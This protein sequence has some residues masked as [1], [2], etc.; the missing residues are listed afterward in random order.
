VSQA[1]VHLTRALEFAARKHRDQRR[2]GATAEP[3]INHLAEVAR[4]VAE[5]TAGQ[6]PV[7]VTA[8]L[9]HDT[10]EDTKTTAEELSREFGPQV[11]AIV[12]EVTDDKRLPKAER[13]RLQVENAPHKSPRAKL[14][15]IAD[16]I[17]N[18]RAIL[19]SPPVDWDSARK[20]EYFEWSVRV[21]AGC[22]GV[23][24]ALEAQFDEVS[25]TGSAEFP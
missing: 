12:E 15:K 11:A 8:A 16:K 24:R 19:A 21:V 17:S 10:I 20:R 25:R 9:L 23:S 22:R 18:L 2:K 6:D 5:A 3:Y 7:V 1:I 4:L 13:K 14:I